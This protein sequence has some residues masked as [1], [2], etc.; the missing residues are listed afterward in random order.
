MNL[1]CRSCIIFEIYHFKS[2]S[3]FRF[4]DRNELRHSAQNEL[5]PRVEHLRHRASSEKHTRSGS[6]LEGLF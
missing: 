5:D 1:Y 2:F 6:G 3:H 4:D